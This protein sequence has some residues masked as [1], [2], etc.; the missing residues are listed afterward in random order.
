MS[1][2]AL[3]VIA[4][5][6]VIG[7]GEFGCR[8]VER[9][10]DSLEELDPEPLRLGAYCLLKARTA[11]P[12]PKEG[13][14]ARVAAA[15]ER[16]S[17]RELFGTGYRLL[18]EESADPGRPVRVFVVVRPGEDE[19]DRW[20]TGFLPALVTE[21]GKRV[22]ARA[23]STC[24]LLPVV[25]FSDRRSVRSHLEVVNRAL[26]G[27]RDAVYSRVFVLDS[28]TERST[29]LTPDQVAEAAAVLLE[30]ALVGSVYGEPVQGRP[31]TLP[32]LL[33]GED[34]LT[35]DPAESPVWCAVG[36]RCV[37]F[38]A[39]LVVDTLATR[40]LRDFIDSTLLADPPEDAAPGNGL[41]RRDAEFVK[42]LPAALDTVPLDRAAARAR[43]GRRALPGPPRRPWGLLTPTGRLR[44]SVRLWLEAWS[45]HF[46]RA[47]AEVL[48]TLREQADRWRSVP[49]GRLELLSATETHVRGVIRQEDYSLPR[50]YRRLRRLRD[51]V[52]EADTT[53]GAD[54]R[55]VTLPPAGH[56]DETLRK[57]AEE[58]GEL[59]AR[60][61]GLL[62]MLVFAV[63]VGVITGVAAVS[64]LASWLPALSLETWGFIARLAAA[65]LCAGGFLWIW[66]HLKHGRVHRSALGLTREF[67]NES[68]RLDQARHE[69]LRSLRLRELS[70]QSRLVDRHL[71]RAVR[72]IRRHLRYLT[73]AVRQLA[74]GDLGPKVPPAEPGDT[75]ITRFIAD[76]QTDEEIYREEIPSGLAVAER[77]GLA[78]REEHVAAA[79]RHLIHGTPSGFYRYA[80]Q[81]ITGLFKPLA[82]RDFLRE[83]YWPRTV[84]EVT[85][86]WKR[87]TVYLRPLGPDA[88]RTHTGTAKVL[89]AHPSYLFELAETGVLA[90]RET[91]AV[92][93]PTF[94]RIYLLRFKYGIPFK[95]LGLG[96]VQS[97]L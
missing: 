27:S 83:R 36:V 78:G 75:L 62:T 91:V 52:A 51:S 16:A 6:V 56:Y 45:E 87:M 57:A 89:L 18:G 77:A 1:P 64:W 81:R 39:Q 4:P 42:R 29:A 38:P 3:R 49:T 50:A 48:E 22:S 60:C 71:D 72:S 37:A 11:G 94:N 13:W 85:E 73:R 90:D 61:P 9:L 41:D 86:L 26:H 28:Y 31:E 12:D 35:D 58:C 63:P 84:D 17:S 70:R 32:R 96:G 7:C 69:G 21:L 59:M 8:V 10:T 2:E 68:A 24:H 74:P 53:R 76:P 5:T 46:K 67:S 80:K 15:A 33:S 65:P 20:C 92:P 43:G 19:G 34:V 79:V 25:A 82:Q 40:G 44:T 88:A 14:V 23:L 30:A 54:L 66:L 97:D 47:R 95:V 55:P 93:V